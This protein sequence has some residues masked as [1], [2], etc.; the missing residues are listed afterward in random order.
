LRG[1]GVIFLTRRRPSSLARSADC[2]ERFTGSGLSGHFPY[3]ALASS[4]IAK[5]LAGF[6]RINEDG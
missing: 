3:L 4:E 6:R 5:N 2:W 1:A